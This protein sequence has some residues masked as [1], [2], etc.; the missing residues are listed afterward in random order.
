MICNPYKSYW[1]LFAKPELKQDTI[2]FGKPEGNLDMGI[3]LVTFQK[4]KTWN[5]N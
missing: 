5:G 3:I 4:M 2:M 1:S